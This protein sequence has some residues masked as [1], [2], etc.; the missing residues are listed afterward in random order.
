MTSWNWIFITDII[1]AKPFYIIE[2]DSLFSKL[3]NRKNR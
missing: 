3:E 2:E 1:N